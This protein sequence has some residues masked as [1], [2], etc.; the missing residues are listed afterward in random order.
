ME[1]EIESF[2]AAGDLSKERIIL[3]AKNNLDV[4]R[5]AILRSRV[6]KSGERDPTA[7]PKIAYWFQ[8]RNVKA[9]D[10]VVLY[11]KK[12]N[13]SIKDIG[14]GRTAYFFY[15]GRSET[16]WGSSDYGAALLDVAEWQFD[17]PA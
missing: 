8:D 3:R 16:L 13:T 4:G 12:G 17:V 9:E 7:G 15:W 14:N 5:Y 6:A 11:T 2:A 10:V 1:L